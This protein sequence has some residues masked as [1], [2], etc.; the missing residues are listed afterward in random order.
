MT[1]RNWCLDLSC[2]LSSAYWILSSSIKFSSM[3]FL[4]IVFLLGDCSDV[5]ESLRDSKLGEMWDMVFGLCL[6]RVKHYKTVTAL[7]LASN[8]FIQGCRFMTAPKAKETVHCKGCYRSRIF[9]FAV[10][11]LGLPLKKIF[12]SNKHVSWA[13]PSSSHCSCFSPFFSYSVSK[14]YLLSPLTPTAAH[15][16]IT[17]LPHS[18]LSPGLSLFIKTVSG[19]FSFA[20]IPIKTFSSKLPI[21]DSILWLTLSE[22]SMTHFSGLLQACSFSIPIPFPILFLPLGV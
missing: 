22:P 17:L 12:F 13:S 6:L 11:V 9:W 7:L 10:V 16:S 5:L 20:T 14:F 4:I 3:Y 18:Y 21:D 15:E 19:L 8:A 1:C 2:F